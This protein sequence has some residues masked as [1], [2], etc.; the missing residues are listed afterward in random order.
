VARLLNRVLVYG[1]VAAVTAVVAYV[2][3]MPG[4]QK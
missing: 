2:T 3:I 4:A 1:V